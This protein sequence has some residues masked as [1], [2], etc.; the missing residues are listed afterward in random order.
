MPLMAKLERTKLD[1][2]G[3]LLV[4]QAFR[5]MLRLKEGEEVQLL[6]DEQ[7]ERIIVSPS[8]EKGRL[9]VEIGLSDD[10]G[11]LAKAADVLADFG[12]DLISTESRSMLRGKQAEWHVLCNASSVKDLQAL[13]KALQAKGVL[14]VTFHKL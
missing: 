3:R 13:K 11:S 1:E 10:P 5:E 14:W 6:L 7:N 12:V 9:L 4:P 8:L 2:K